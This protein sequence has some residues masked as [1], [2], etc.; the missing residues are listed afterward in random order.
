M[1]KTHAPNDDNQSKTACGRPATGHE[2]R[3]GQRVTCDNCL[4]ANTWTRQAEEA[5][6]EAEVARQDDW[7]YRGVPE[8]T[9]DDPCARFPECRHD[10]GAY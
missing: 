3:D 8:C 7:E 10:G 9:P 6:F 2:T 5:A 4:R 1:A